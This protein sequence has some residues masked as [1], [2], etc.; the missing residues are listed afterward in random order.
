VVVAESIVFF[1]G[2]D[3]MADEGEEVRRR[4]PYSVA[5]VFMNAATAGLA[6]FMMLAWANEP[7]FLLFFVASASL[8]AVSRFFFKMRYFSRAV[9]L[10]ELEQSDVGKSIRDRSRLVWL[11][12][13]LAV[14]VSL[15]LLIFFLT[16]VLSISVWLTVLSS[17]ASGLGFSELVFYVCCKSKL[18][19]E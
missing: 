8:L 1:H 17:L 9:K 15:P 10:P 3:M 5:W 7:L 11:L 12:L 16:R 19:E 4:Y 6:V 14:V 2:C 13:V 18:I